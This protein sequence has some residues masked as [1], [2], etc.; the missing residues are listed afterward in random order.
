MST[1]NTPAAPAPAPGDAHGVCPWWLG[2]LLASPIRR[3]FEKPERIVGPF[4]APGITVLEPGCGMGF[5]SIPLARLVGP[6][7]RV[8][9]VDLQAKMLDGLRR[10]ARRAGV[11]DRIE[12][13]VA[14]PTDLRIDA[15]AGK[16]DLALAIHVIHELP[17][18]RAFLRQLHRAL[19]PGGLLVV[20]EPK[21]HVTEAAFA[22]TVALAEG[23]GFVRGPQ[24]LATRRLGAVFTRF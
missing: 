2:P 18:A 13:V 5:F 10:R 20:S 16:V 24:T 6:A 1:S 11:Q 9:C 17:D 8:V 22:E 14:G 12:T 19:R 21:G 3:F 7:G 15:W 23:V 4:T